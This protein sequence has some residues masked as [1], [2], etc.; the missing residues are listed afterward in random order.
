MALNM[1]SYLFTNR[2][3][4]IG[5][6][7]LN[8][9]STLNS[10]SLDMIQ[11]L[12]CLLSDWRNDKDIHAVVIKSCS[13]KAFCAGGDIRFFYKA[14][15]SAIPEDRDLL[16]DFFTH[17]YELNYLIHNYPKPYVSILNGIVM[18]GG[19]GISQTNSA[20]RINIVTEHTRMAMPEVNIGL[21]PDVGGS[22]FL[23]RLPEE[24]GIYLGMTGEVIGASGALFA[25]LADAFIPSAELSTFYAALE[26]VD[27]GDYRALAT[28]FSKLYSKQIDIAHCALA[29]YRRLIQRH[30]S[31]DSVQNIVNSLRKDPHPFAQETAETILK[32][33][34]L[35][36][37]VTS[38]QLRRAKTMS[39]SDC[40]RMERTMMHHCFE[41]GDA[42]EGI[43]AA[44]I[45]KDNQP[46][47]RP[48]SLED[49][50][51]EMVARFF[52][53]VWAEDAHPLRHLL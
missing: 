32:R 3:S 12:T 27:N 46:Q 6:I 33:S 22:Y 13:T 29:Q 51:D 23:S 34:P 24:M 49:V 19:M 26:T 41:H 25:G 28:Q 35:M 50:T 44:I 53:P 17:E 42:I 45:D 10:L 7:T 37:C 21:F 39:F 40:L 1:S 31:Q 52:E 5:V 43:R 16:G 36:L 14:S 4:S 15:R 30:F 38:E 9:P 2:S 8:R 20:A 18:G 47:W 48:T 11:K